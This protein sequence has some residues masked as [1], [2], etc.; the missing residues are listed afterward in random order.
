MLNIFFFRRLLMMFLRSQVFEN[1][2]H[3]A[4]AYL[5]LLSNIL[6]P[7]GLHRLWMGINGWWLFPGAF[8]LSAVGTFQYLGTHVSVW[9]LL[10]IP[11]VLLLVFDAC[12]IA[13]APVRS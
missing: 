10:C 2:T 8:I 3:R 9:R 4:G 13:V 12:V 1:L 5:L 7:L 6:L 11:Y